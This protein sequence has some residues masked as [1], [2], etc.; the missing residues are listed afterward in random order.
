MRIIGTFFQ[1][2]KQSKYLSVTFDSSTM[3]SHLSATPSGDHHNPETSIPSGDDHDDGKIKKIESDPAKQFVRFLML[4]ILLCLVWDA[5]MRPPQDRWLTKDTSSQ[6]L[7]Y[8]QANPH[9]AIFAFL[10]VIAVCVVF[11]I[12]V[13]TPLTLGCGYIYK[14]V[15]GWVGGIGIATGVSMAGSALGAVLCFL[16][17]RYLMR[18]RVRLWIRKYPIF[19]AID[20]AL[21][22]HGV[23]IM[24]MLYLTPVLPLGP[25]SYM[26][27]TTSMRLSSFVLAKVASLPLMML[28]V[29]IGA[30]A[31]TL[32]TD[33]DA[34][35]NNKVLILSG[36]GLSMLMIGGISYYIRQEL[37]TV[38]GRVCVH[39]CVRVREVFACG[40]TPCI[41]LLLS[42][43]H[44]SSKIQIHCFSIQILEKQA[45][46]RKKLAMDDVVEEDD[47]DE[48]EAIEMGTPS[49][50]GN[51][52]RQRRTAAEIAD[53]HM[54]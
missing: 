10:I 46:Q 30:S 41:V 15:Y 24:A 22:E 16:L 32:L 17:G 18:D 53:E 35:E 8:A 33:T 50:V 5:T 47:E 4:S 34:I 45:K 13:G 25:V 12:P 20:T 48:S 54:A 27:G 26:V 51:K 19:D 11:M 40:Y 6:F 28:Y 44:L 43:D 36:I 39:A 29:F 49:H 37:M 1:C 23:R 21:A 14:G 7:Q 52:T 31:G 3:I 38:R 2:E 42:I 9:S